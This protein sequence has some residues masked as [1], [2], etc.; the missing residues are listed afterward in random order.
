[1]NPGRPPVVLGVDAGNSKT[2]AVV[3][4]AT[5]EVL[6]YGR[7]GCG[8][9]Y[10]VGA[11]PGAV[12]EVLAAVGRALAMAGA[13]CEDLSDGAPLTPSVLTNAAFCLAGIDWDDD[14]AFWRAELARTMPGLGRFSLHNDGFAL[15]RAGNPDGRGVAVSVG[16]G[17]AV[18]AR[19][20]T[21]TEWSASFWIVDGAGGTSLGAEAYAAVVRADLGIGPST[22]LTDALL[23]EHGYRDVEALLV[24]TTGRGTAPV[25]HAALARAVLDAA[26]DGDDVAATIVTEQ[27]RGL[28]DYAE[29]AAR[30]VGFG[31]E[32]VPV[33]LGGSVLSSANPALRN[34]TTTALL[35]R[36]RACR[37]V[38]T[39]RSPVVGAVAEALAE[40][41]AG[42]RPDALAR[43]TGFEFPAEF[44]LT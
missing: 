27:A 42:L 39:P 33:V 10:G 12:V 20:P 34:A 40:S 28:A 41:P 15:L 26:R 44:L 18:V 22:T 6:G 5:G 13:R 3:A 29:A 38:L 7:A 2:V 35:E 24:G 17:G 14:L 8:D 4:N 11:E 23:A 31:A 36:I 43:L 32:E 25:R 19:G 16:T 21:G 37:V 30:R 1:M 9:I